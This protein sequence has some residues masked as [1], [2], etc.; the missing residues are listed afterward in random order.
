MND[1]LLIRGLEK[2]NPVKKY[3]LQI[4]FIN[5]K[6]CARFM[7]LKKIAG[8]LG[9]ESLI[10]VLNKDQLEERNQRTGFTGRIGAK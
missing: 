10:S 7:I 3:F 4:V 8:I 5:A 6:T 9:Y 1:F 2:S